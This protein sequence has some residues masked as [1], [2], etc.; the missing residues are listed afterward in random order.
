MLS[1][2]AHAEQTR[3]AT[4]DGFQPAYIA[5]WGSGELSRRVEL[6]VKKLGDC[7]L[8][9]RNCQ[10]N[11]LQDKAKVCRTGRYASVSSHFAHFGEESCLRGRFG[12]GT[13]FFGWCNLRCVFCQ[14]YEISWLGEGHIVKPEELA[15]MMLNLQN[16]GCHNINLVTP[17]H[18]V[19]QILEALLLA[20]EGGLQLPLVYNTG[21]YDSLDS[22]ALLDGVVDIYMPDFKFWDPEKAK[23]YAKAP[24]YPEVAR[25]AIVEMHRQVGSLV[26]DQHGLALRGVL[27]RHLVM[28]GGMAETVE[29][30]RWIARELGPETYVNVMAQYRPAGRVSETEYPEIDRAITPN[31]FQQA[32]HAIYSAGLHRLDPDWKA[33]MCDDKPGRVQDE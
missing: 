4:E 10:V 29:I 3:P 31:E 5:L 11:R 6:G 32:V 24:D 20:V 30:M 2:M 9:P 21:A 1:A 23:R 22:L 25:R 12:S 19:P 16:Q 28:P 17:T 18:V 8:C 14:N 33:P 15:E 7:T 27:L 26:V 13:I